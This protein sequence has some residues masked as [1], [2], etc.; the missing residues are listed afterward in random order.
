MNEQNRKTERINTNQHVDES[1][2]RRILAVVIGLI[3]VLLG[4]RFIFKLAG[5]NPENT[6][7][8]LIYRVTNYMVAIFESIFS[9]I[10]NEGLETDSIF[11]PGTLIAMVVVA[12]IGF[13]I[14]K[15]FNQNTSVRKNTEVNTYDNSSGQQSNVNHQ[16]NVDRRANVD[17]RANDDSQTN[18][19]PQA[20]VD[21]Q[22]N[23]N[24]QANAD[25]QAND[26]QANV[27]GQ[28]SVDHRT[29]VNHQGVVDPQHNVD[30]RD[31][32]DRT[33]NI[34]HTTNINE[35]DKLR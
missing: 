1:F 4:A 12:L 8:N 34:D 33:T 11:E 28:D 14:F 27:D 3:E 32:V 2:P 10:T 25:R 30:G 16:D 31:N 7:I 24:R 17:H 21:G 29:D 22:S 6:V 19:D 23:V 18:V 5:A 35:D 13:A 15:L 26:P 9:P 20:N